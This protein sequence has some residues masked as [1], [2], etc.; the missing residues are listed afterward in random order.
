M[1]R[2]VVGKVLE[3]E[4]NNFPFNY[5][6]VFKVVVEAQESFKKYPAD[7]GHNF[8]NHAF[9]TLLNVFM[10]LDR[11]NVKYLDE[12]LCAS[13]LHDRNRTFLGHLP[14][15]VMHRQI[16]KKAGL[17][18][19]FQDRV[20]EIISTHSEFEQSEPFKTEKTILFLADKS[21]YA[22]WDRAEVALK[23]MPVWMVDWYKKKWL[24]KINK[25]EQK[26]IGYRQQYPTF[27]SIFEKNLKRANEK[28][29]EI[30]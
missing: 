1:E 27:V 21:E 2:V 10:L 23:T 18:K 29:R 3:I 6:L 24:K 28:V 12:L 13:I 30:N 4:K 11:T 19:D 7:G 8:D 22:N 25:V 15:D 5:E 9:P 14:T 16:M 17:E 20:M 26:V